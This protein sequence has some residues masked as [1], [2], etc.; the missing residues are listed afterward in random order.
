MVLS[1]AMGTRNLVASTD[2]AADETVP[3]GAGLKVPAADVD[4]LRD[5]LSAMI[6]DAVLRQRC[7]DASWE[8]GQKR[9]RS[10]DTAAIISGV[11][12]AVNKSRVRARAALVRFRRGRRS[13]RVYAA[14]LLS[15]RAGRTSLRSMRT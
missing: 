4:A 7:A 13:L 12:G 11:I 1:E 3:E 6:G 9:T 15:W 8:A 14:T 10:A 5:A 2:G